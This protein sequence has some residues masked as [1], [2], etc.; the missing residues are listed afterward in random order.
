VCVCVCVRSLRASHVS[1]SSARCLFPPHHS[2]CFAMPG[3]RVVRHLPDTYTPPPLSS[4]RTPVTVDA[5]GVATVSHICQT[6]GTVGTG[7][8]GA[9][10]G[11]GVGTGASAGVGAGASAGAGA[12]TGAGAGAGAGAGVGGAVN[13]VG[14]R[15]TATTAT[16]GA[17][18]STGSGSASHAESGA[19]AGTVAGAG[20]GAGTG[21]G[22][23]G[24][25]AAGSSS[26]SSNGNTRPPQ[27]PSASEVPCPLV[28]RLP[29]QFEVSGS[30]RSALGRTCVV[31]KC[32]ATC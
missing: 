8:G 27:P 4:N 7:P 22:T 16:G 18:T 11:V 12:G 3:H 31:W 24:G 1:P 2:P 6:S 23:M 17:G 26:G 5:A 15:V 32:V 30:P 21:A 9:A 10:T 13:A 25:V 14:S 20:M 28:P 29:F 19:G